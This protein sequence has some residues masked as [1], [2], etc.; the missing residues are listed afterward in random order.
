MRECPCTWQGL[1]AAT[2]L[3]S[4]PHAVTWRAVLHWA[5]IHRGL[6]PS[7][8]MYHSVGEDLHPTSWL[9]DPVRTGVL[10]SP[11]CF[12]SVLFQPTCDSKAELRKSYACTC[13]FSAKH[14]NFGKRFTTCELRVRTR[15]PVSTAGVNITDT[16]RHEWQSEHSTP[17]QAHQFWS[18]CRWSGL[19]HPVLTSLHS[20]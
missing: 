20:L 11:R 16:V 10:P 1:Y 3:I 12:V 6:H 7:T 4:S 15:P 9:T 5:V 18:T 17:L 8:V 13:M 19:A 2:H 14:C